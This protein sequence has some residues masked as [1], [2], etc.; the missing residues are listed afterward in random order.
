VDPYQNTKSRYEGSTT[1]KVLVPRSGPI[2]HG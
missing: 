1:D 2:A